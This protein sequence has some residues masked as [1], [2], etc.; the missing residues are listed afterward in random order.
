[1]K[2]NGQNS[3][4]ILYNSLNFA[5]CGPPNDP[6]DRC[7]ARGGFELESPAVWVSRVLGWGNSESHYTCPTWQIRSQLAPNIKNV[8]LI[9]H[10]DFWTLHRLFCYCGMFGQVAGLQIPWEHRSTAHRKIFKWQKKIEVKKK[11]IK[12]VQITYNKC[13]KIQL[14]LHINEQNKV[15]LNFKGI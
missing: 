14:W 7:A 15:N 5:P 3:S 4:E 8:V 9:Q 1:M 10:S 13:S 11:K 12:V 6:S 2:F